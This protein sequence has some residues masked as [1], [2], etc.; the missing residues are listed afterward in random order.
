MRCWNPKP[1]NR[2][3][4]GFTLVELLVVITI[5]GILIALLLPAVQAAREA[6][7]RMQCTN[8][9]KQMGLGLLNHESQMGHFPTNGFWSSGVGAWWI[10]QP[11]GGFAEK[12]VGGWFYNILPFIEQQSFH[13]IGS[14]NETQRRSLWTKAVGNA[15]PAGNCPTRRAAIG[16]GLGPYANTNNFANIDKPTTVAKLDYACNAGSTEFQWSMDATIFGKHTGICYGRSLVKVADIRDGT[17]NTYAVGEKCIPPD[18]YIPQD[19]VMFGWGD[20]AC[21]YSAHDWSTARYCYHDATTPANSY[22]PKQD[23]SG[24]VG[25]T[26][27]AVFGSAHSSSFNMAFCDGSVHTIS[28]SIDPA[29]HSYL[30]NRDD[31]KTIDGSKY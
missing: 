27:E 9:L 19:G 10:G 30:G 16:Y 3:L 11:D 14:G 8:N 22:S 4:S 23:Q 20:N 28:Y 6:A 13:D 25:V 29:T 18:S 15:V 12:Q 5:I 24:Y 1:R 21:A 7:R 17:S 26:T 31:G 2:K